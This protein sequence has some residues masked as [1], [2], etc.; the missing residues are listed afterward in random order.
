MMGERGGDI[1]AR[2]GIIPRFS[3]SLYSSIATRPKAAFRVEISYFEIY[4]E[5][6]YD[7]LGGHEKARMKVR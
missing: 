2:A 5:V 1:T 6:I 3:R 4:S 7:L